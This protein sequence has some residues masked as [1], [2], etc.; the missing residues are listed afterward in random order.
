MYSGFSEK[1]QGGGCFFLASLR[2]EPKVD[3]KTPIL[4]Y[5]TLI[6]KEGSSRG[7]ALSNGSNWLLFPIIIVTG[8]REFRF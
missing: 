7:S 2:L 5:Q 8:D 4:L 1:T 6:I 3:G